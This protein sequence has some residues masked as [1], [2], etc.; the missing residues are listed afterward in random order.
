MKHMVDSTEVFNANIGGWSTSNVVDNEWNFP[1]LQSLRSQWNT[2]QVTNMTLM[3]GGAMAE[4]EML[5]RGVHRT[6]NV[7]VIAGMYRC[8]VVKSVLDAYA[9][10]VDVQ[11]AAAFDSRTSVVEYTSSLISASGMF[12]GATRLNQDIG[13]GDTSPGYNTCKECSRT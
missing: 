11:L 1:Q 7:K 8:S 12:E 13:T 6:S 5:V 3:F 9:D 4:T 10:E 2:S